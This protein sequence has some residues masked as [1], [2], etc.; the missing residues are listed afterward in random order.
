M[1]RRVVITGMGTVNPLGHNTSD[2]WQAIRLGKSGVGPITKF[3]TSLYT[4]KI[5]A[6]I[7][8]FDVRDYMD[9]KEA[10]KMEAFSHYA[11]V[12]ALE[13]WKQSEMK[14]GDY[15]PFR[16]GVVLGVGM[17]GFETLEKAFETLNTRGPSRVAPMTIP[18]LISNIGPGNIAI[19][20]NAQGPSYSLATA[21][22]SGTDAIGQSVM[23]IKSGMTDVMVSGGV[24]AV[25]VGLG[26]ASFNAIHALSTKYNDTPEKAS[27]PFDKDRDGFVMGEGAGVLVL[28]ELD[29]ALRRGAPILAEVLAEGATTDAFHLTAPHPDARGAIKAMELALRAAQ[30]KP[31]HIDYINAHGT[32]TPVN[33]PVETKAIKAVFGDHAKK[34]KVSSTKSM[35][36]HCIGAA[37]AIEAIIC[38]KAMEDQYFPPTINLDN[39]DPDCDL[40]YV[41]NKGYEGKIDYVM[42]NSLGFGGHNGV[43]LMKRYTS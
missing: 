16:V 14:E 37:G 7:K 6:E 35:T 20:L 42:S 27:R 12:S 39:P 41:P 5:A 40:D 11:V 2:F 36:G 38:V 33:D 13:A 10:Q 31:E 18:K 24:E 17:G 29:H 28:E 32:S 15:D 23:M 25:I 1:S 43:L 34:L 9:R 22:A 26:I 30:V 4:T 19:T 3:D 21:C 8:N